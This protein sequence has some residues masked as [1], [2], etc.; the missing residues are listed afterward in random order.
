MFD[1][2]TQD[3]FSKNEAGIIAILHKINED[4]SQ[5]EIQ[6]ENQHYIKPFT[7][8]SALLLR[9]QHSDALLF[10]GSTDVA[11]LQT[12]KRIHLAKVLDLSSIDEL[13]FIVEDHSRL[14]IGSGTSLE[15][16]HDYT[17]ERMPYL[18]DILKVFGS[19]QIRNM[20]TIG[21]NV[22]TAS[23]ISDTLPV[24]IA[25]ESQVRLMKQNGQRDLPLEKFIVAYRKTAI[26]EDELIVMLSFNKPAK[27]EIIKSYKISKRKDLDIASV[28]ACFRLKLDKSNHIQKAI[29]AFG[30]VAAMPTRAKKTE[31]FVL[32][33]PWNRDTANRASQILLDEFQPIS[34][35]RSTADARKLM[36]R[37][38]L[39]K[40]W[41]DTKS[42]TSNTSE[43][44]N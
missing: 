42:E 4:K 24:L 43:D 16:L 21:G 11:L 10:G 14:A 35:A 30:G 23:P 13:D 1:G 44:E 33:K 31:T 28:S 17:K 6:A 38:L 9:K 41:D 27:N 22:G 3:Q 34:D 29:F 8:E 39:I 12:K 26:A 19:L 32:G 7:I 18:S 5:L 40:F 37:N 2:D 20:A 25:L 15:E 36:I